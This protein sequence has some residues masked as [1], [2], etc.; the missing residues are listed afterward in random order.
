MGKIKAQVE[1]K[2]LEALDPTF[3]AG[4]AHT[5]R[6][7]IT[8][9]TGQQW[10][11]DLELYL[12]VTKVATSGVGSIVIDAGA[13]PQLVEPYIDGRDFTHTPDYNYYAERLSSTLARVTEVFG[14][15]DKELLSGVQQS[16]LFDSFSEKEPGQGEEDGEND[17]DRVTKKAK[18]KVEKVSGTATLDQWM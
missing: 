15:S 16:S 10:T 8:N 1:M 3:E 5:A 2:G 6:A 11:Y 7:T 9:P 13:K 12:G 4:S 14:V 17:P 18:R